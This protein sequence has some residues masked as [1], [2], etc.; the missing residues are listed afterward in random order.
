MRLIRVLLSVLLTICLFCSCA[1]R[2]ER[3]PDAELFFLDVGQGSATLLRT[4]EGDLLVDAGS[5]ASQEVLCHRMREIGVESLRLVVFTHF[6]E[7]HVGGGDGILEAFSV[8]EI[9][10]N[11]SAEEN[12]SVRR[13][14][15]AAAA[16]S[17]P[18]NSVSIGDQLLLGGFAV[19]VLYPEAQSDAEGN[20]RSLV[21]TVRNSAFSLLLMGDA[22][23]ET[24]A[25]LMSLYGEAQIRT[26]LLLVGHHGA[27]TSASAAFLSV[28][29]PEWAIISCGA[30]NLFG[31]PDGR[32]LAR[33]TDAGAEI[34]RTDLM[35]EIS[36]GIDKEGYWLTDRK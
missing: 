7:D 22:G 9:W 21:L 27:S 26:D 29:K 33:L 36:V 5:E 20:E 31:H 13:L 19:T 2:E 23:E 3:K 10:V 32:T 18:I 24:E 14:R 15:D 28:A 8:E 11:G 25:E 35:G 4:A 12:E 17:V 1:K 34:Y 16:R 6:D 30:G